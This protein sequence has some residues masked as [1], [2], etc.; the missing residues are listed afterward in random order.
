MAANGFLSTT[1]LDLAAY[2]NNLKQYLR[3]QPRFQDYDFEGSNLSVLLD[4]LAYN[5]YQNAL[6]LNMVGSEMFLDTAQ[7]R[8]SIVSHAKELNYVPR[9]RS[10]ARVDLRIVVPTVAGTPDTITVPKYYK[11]LGKDNNNNSTYYFTTD[12]AT[13]LSRANNYTADIL[14]YEGIEN[15]EVFSYGN[16]VILSS[17]DIDTSSIT[18]FVRDSEQTS[19]LVEWTRANDLFGLEANDK[20]FF[21]QGA[22]GY[23]YEISFGNDLVGKA[24][25]PGNIVYVQYRVSS[26]SDANGITRFSSIQGIEGNSA[27]VSLVEL[28]SKSTGGSFQETNESIRFNAAK[29]F[30]TQ[31][32]AITSLDFISL[33]KTYFP[34]LKNVIAYGGEEAT[35]PRFGKVLI[36]AIPFEGT[37]VSEPLKIQIQ[38]FAKSR[39]TLSIEPIFVDPDFIYVDLLTNVKYNSSSTTKTATQLSTQVNTAILNYVDVSLN[40]FNADLR[41]SRLTKAIDDADIAIV[42]NETK[43]RLVK[44]IIPEF[45]VPFTT[46]WNFENALKQDY[47]GKKYTTE[48]PVIT[49]TPFFYNNIEVSI[50]DDGLGTLFIVGDGIDNISCGTVDYETGTISITSLLVTGFDDNYIKLYALPQNLDIET[51]TNKVLLLEEEDIAINVVASRE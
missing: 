49:S 43:L 30:Q 29:F 39:T 6:Y 2:K 51:K 37:I 33:I 16:R 41:F 40:D 34:S 13:V 10:S 48:T 27:E 18:V 24:L 20:V 26:G 46:T 28:E 32:R 50:E 25:I 9:S 22:S 35:P 47:T 36:S 42:S 23:K 19:E 1:Q 21:L 5:T 4:V 17:E 8:E 7:L 15:T 14:F 3:Q 38:N 31:E 12:E 45:N 44:R 11:V